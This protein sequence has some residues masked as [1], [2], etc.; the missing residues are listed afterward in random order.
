[1]KSS[2]AEPQGAHLCESTYNMQVYLKHLYANIVVISLTPSLI[3]CRYTDAPVVWQCRGRTSCGVYQLLDIQ[4]HLRCVR[5]GRLSRVA[6]SI[7][8]KEPFT[9]APKRQL[10]LFGV[11]FPGGCNDNRGRIRTPVCSAGSFISL[12]YGACVAVCARHAE[13][14]RNIIFAM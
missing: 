7:G 13:R 11:A 10:E 5:G 14:Q 9:L 4:S 6:F 12:T 3:I 8:N 1:M 2:S